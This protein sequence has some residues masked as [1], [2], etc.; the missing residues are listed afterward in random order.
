MLHIICTVYYCLRYRCRVVC[1]CVVS[2]ACLYVFDERA[3]WQSS[4][5]WCWSSSSQLCCPLG[6]HLRRSRH[7]WVCTCTVCS[8]NTLQMVQQTILSSSSSA[9]YFVLHPCYIT[10]SCFCTSVMLLIVV[11]YS[12][13]FCGV[14]HDS[15]VKLLVHKLFLMFLLVQL[16]VFNSVFFLLLFFPQRCSKWY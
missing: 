11:Q 9:L 8:G 5:D 15:G 4:T 12:G 13:N 10:A 3:A 16:Q 7:V 1:V 2:Y 14:F 6:P